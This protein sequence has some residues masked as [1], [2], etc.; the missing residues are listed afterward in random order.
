MKVLCRGKMTVFE[1]KE[2]FRFEFKCFFNYFFKNFSIFSRMKILNLF[3]SVNSIFFIWH[4]TDFM[5][6]SSP[7]SSSSALF[8]N[9]ACSVFNVVSNAKSTRSKVST[10]FLL[11]RVGRGHRNG[12]DPEDV[13]GRGV[14]IKG[15]SDGDV[16]S[17]KTLGLRL[18]L[19]LGI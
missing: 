6:N 14:R 5:K 12:E 19:G 3:F 10:F 2:H 17:V 18:V 16:V 8:S 15:G 1:I 11:L 9:F 13:E 7:S 4:N